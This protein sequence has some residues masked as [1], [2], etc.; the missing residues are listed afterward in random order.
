MALL[1]SSPDISQ[2]IRIQAPA[3]QSNFLVLRAQNRGHVEKRVP[4]T[5]AFPCACVKFG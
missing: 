1:Q 2:R 5:S 3:I 4:V